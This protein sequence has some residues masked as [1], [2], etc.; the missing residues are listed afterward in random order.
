VHKPVLFSAVSS[1]SGFSRAGWFELAGYG[2]LPALRTGA[3]RTMSSDSPLAVGTRLGS[4]KITGRIG[5]G[6]MGT[7]YSAEH[8]EL[9]KRV[10]IKTLRGELAANGQ[11]R[12]RFVREGRAA[13]AV[14]HPHVVDVHDVGLHGEIP[15][16]VMELLQGHDLAAHVASAGKLEIMEVADLM[17]P[18]LTAMSEAHAAGIV[19]RDLKPENIFLQRGPGNSWSPKVL[20]FGI[21]KLR[22]PESMNLTGSGTLLGTPYYMAPEQASS[23]KDV[24]SRADLYSIG[25]ILY[26]CVSGQ[27]PFQ[28]S[29]LVQVI[30]QILT[31]MP[32]PLR[33]SVPDIPAAFEQVVKKAMAKDAG[34]RFQHARD[35]AR[36]LLPFA[37][38]RTRLNFEHLL[39][40][41]PEDDASVSDTAVLPGGATPLPAS[42]LDPTASSV[43]TD[44]PAPSSSTRTVLFAI[45]TVLVLVA[46]VVAM[47]LR[48]EPTAVAPT[49][50]ASE[51]PISITGTP[52]P[53]LQ[54][55]TAVPAVPPKPPVTPTATDA[56]SAA[57]PPTQ[58]GPMTARPH[59]PQR[60]H[61]PAHHPERPTAAT[62]STP[63]APKPPA[64][65]PFS[66]RK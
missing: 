43:L 16:L 23:A 37:S 66:E 3:P 58:S 10:A 46:V 32:P 24:D 9:G 45:A 13:A 50:P 6:G 49:P 56:G 42:T 25:V 40:A 35:F 19:H 29:S 17:L 51:T 64:D 47:K 31:A 60:T 7:V 20:D 33:D 57:T 14:R 2:M 55:P 44:R 54:T 59:K 34:A 21:S 48:H 53:P 63:T 38:E 26:H 36:S 28:G 61:A 62:Q 5:E 18:V 52:P 27:V 8:V 41:K 4:Y 22:D 39:A 15:Y 11:V 65:D 1:R 12:A 30:G